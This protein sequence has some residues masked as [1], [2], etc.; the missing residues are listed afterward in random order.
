MATSFIP[1]I[2][3]KNFIDNM[4]WKYLWL[5]YEVTSKKQF[6]KYQN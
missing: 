5:N 4:K 6:R 2:H 3:L 1:R